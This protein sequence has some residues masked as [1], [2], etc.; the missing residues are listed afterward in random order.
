[1]IKLLD[2]PSEELAGFCRRDVFGTRI[3]GYF[4]TYGTS[5]SFACFYMQKQKGNVTAALSKIDSSITL[6]ASPNADF[7]ELSNFLKVIGFAALTCDSDF[8][9]ITGLSPER[10]GNIVCFNARKSINAS[11]GIEISSDIELAQI[12]NILLDAGFYLPQDRGVWLSDAGARFNKGLASACTVFSDK[13]PVA[14]A[15]ILFETASAGLIGAVAT[16]PEHRGKGYAGAL[17]TA[18]ARKLNTKGKRADL[19]C[20]EKLT[21]FYNNLGF[22]KTGAWAQIKGR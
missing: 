8:Q 1:M 20:E 13:V 19:M 7:E 4:E 2:G 5:E 9:G 3:S 12:Y 15:M 6:S 18:L 17:V 14:C 16:L 11:R 10:T 21:Q 22:E